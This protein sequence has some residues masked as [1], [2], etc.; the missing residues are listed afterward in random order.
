MNIDT[1]SNLLDIDLAL[2]V[3]E[4]FQLNE[5]EMANILKE[6]QKSVKS[7]KSIALKI[8]IKNSEIALMSSA[9]RY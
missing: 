2:S 4:Y 5:K 3:G 8:G 9:F 6:V 7:W 1:S